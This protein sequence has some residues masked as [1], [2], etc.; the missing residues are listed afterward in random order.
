MIDIIK[1][2]EFSRLK[3]IS[4]LGGY[5]FYQ[6]QATHTR[7]E[8]CIGTMTFVDRILEGIKKNSFKL[9]E[10]EENLTLEHG[11]RK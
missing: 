8:H 9:N 1:T 10:D 6:K 3:K 4:Q 11:D 5:R 7:F 2:N